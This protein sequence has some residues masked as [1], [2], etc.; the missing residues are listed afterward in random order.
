MRLNLT[1]FN[2]IHVNQ[3]PIILFK[4]IN[5]RLVKLGVTKNGMQRNMFAS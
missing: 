1:L 4:I 5:S 2:Q 3:S